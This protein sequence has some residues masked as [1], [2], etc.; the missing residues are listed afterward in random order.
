MALRYSREWT[1]LPSP[2]PLLLLFLDTA[3]TP[4]LRLRIRF[5]TA[6]NRKVCLCHAHPPTP[7]SQNLCFA[8]AP[9]SFPCHTNK[10]YECDLGPKSS[11]HYSSSSTPRHIRTE[12]VTPASPEVISNLITSLSVIS[13][14]ATAHFDLPLDLLQEPPVSP[15]DK[16]SVPRRLGSFGVDYGAFS[17]P[18]SSELRQDTTDVDD[19]AA[20]PPVIKTAKPPSGLSP[21]TA[22]KSPSRRDSGGGLRSFL[23][24]SRPS[25]R[26]SAA[27]RDADAHSLGN[28]SV[29]RGLSPASSPTEVRKARSQDSW[30]KKAGRSQKGLMYMS[31]KERLQE[32]EERKRGSIGNG[33]SNGLASSAMARTSNPRMDP[34]L[35]QV[36]ISEEPLSLDELIGAAA[37][38]VAGGDNTSARPIPTRD[39]SLRK[40][41]VNAKRSSTRTNRSSK[42][43]SDH[44]AIPEEDYF[45]IGIAKTTDDSEDRVDK[46]SSFK[47]G[48]SLRRSSQGP[49][50]ER[51]AGEGFLDPSW[52]APAKANHYIDRYVTDTENDMDD[53]APSP[54]IAQGKR[55][56]RDFSSDRSSRRRSGR[57]TPELRVKRSSSR[58]KRLSGPLSP[59]AEEKPKDSSSETTNIVYERPPSA[60]SIDDAVEAYLR[61]PRLSQKIRHP[62]TG[63]VI[64]FSEV[65]DADGSAVFCCVG[66]GL[67]RYITAFYDELALTLKL[68]LIT[69]DRPGVGDSESYAE[70]TATPL[71]WP[72]KSDQRF[73]VLFV[74]IC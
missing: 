23:S 63:R 38:A 34:F 59:R 42:R 36:A 65:G 22:Q 29:E 32:N 20:A 15:A 50:K 62:Q 12:S 46:R 16:P 4:T 25:S 9:H 43:D 53:G 27:S 45:N 39:S 40:T 49:R 69:P 60:D 64:S 72:G 30:G 35:A 18:S 41:G 54:H 66:M 58:L 14:P 55:R 21:L 73:P 8:P 67:T 47:D 13:R 17:K 56:D 70:G 11:N 10:T 3:G 61:S 71:G 52:A 51:A 44:S 2:L 24:S 28:I 48:E 1:S 33:S 31:S 6:E 68:R 7:Q 57:S 5:R 19:L 74:K 26:G 37:A